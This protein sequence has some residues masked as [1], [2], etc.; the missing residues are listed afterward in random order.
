MRGRVAGC[1]PSEGRGL[2]EDRWGLALL[3]SLGVLPGPSTELGPSRCLQEPWPW[4]RLAV[5]M[6]V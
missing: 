6:A 2:A 4:D 5:E 1:C 3:S